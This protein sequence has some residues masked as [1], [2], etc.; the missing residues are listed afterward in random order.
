MTIAWIS[1]F[2]AMNLGSA[3]RFE[4]ILSEQFFYYPETLVFPFAHLSTWIDYSAM[5]C[6]S[7]PKLSF[8]RPSGM[9]V[10]TM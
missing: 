5:N 2:I 10:E 1:G 7:F 6:R 3:L 4:L 9:A 8:T